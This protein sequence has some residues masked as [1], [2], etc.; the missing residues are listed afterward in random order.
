MSQIRVP[1]V[2][3]IALL[4]SSMCAWGQNSPRAAGLTSLNHIVVLAQENRSL[5]HYFGALRQYWR[6]NGYPDRSFDGLPQF[7]PTSGLPPLFHAAPTNPGCDPAFPPPADCTFDSASPKIASYHLI[8]QCTENTSP[9][10]NESH[11]FWDLND[12][13]GLSKAKLNGYVWTAG[14]D[15]RA[16]G[17]YD[18]DGIRAMGYYTDAD[19][20]YYYFMATNFSTSDK[21]F[22]PAMTRTH[23][24]REYLVAATSQ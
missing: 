3:G 21:W 2:A 4:I 13:T 17:Y 8:T 24:N 5:D 22:S 18:S 23:P 11:E 14:H 12:V 15:G 9:S 10:W 16:N 20:N 19:L 7:N 1:V 6:N